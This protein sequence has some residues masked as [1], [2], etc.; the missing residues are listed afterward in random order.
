MRTFTTEIT[1]N[2]ERGFAKQPLIHGEIP[3]QI[4][5]A[6][7]EV[8]R[9]LGP[10]LLESAYEL[11][12]HHELHC[13]GLQVRRQVE[14]PIKYDG[15]VLDAGYRID[16]LVADAVIVEVKS[17]EK[18]DPIHE[19]QMLS[20]MKLAQKRVGLLINFNGQML[21]NGIRRKVL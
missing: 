21:K 14:L 15:I 6:A 13:R 2:T 17:V 3:E 7:L 18:F 11:C 5:D 10:G 12:V 1:E 4:L 20:Y 8:H 16:L 9:H 19:A